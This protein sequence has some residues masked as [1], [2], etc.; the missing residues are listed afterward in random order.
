MRNFA[1]FIFEFFYAFTGNG[2]L[3]DFRGYGRNLRRNNI[4][5]SIPSRHCQRIYVSWN[6]G[7]S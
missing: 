2:G 5:T 1:I 3:E 7:D 6:L 4:I